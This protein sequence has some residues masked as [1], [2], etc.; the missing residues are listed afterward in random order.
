MSK[1]TKRACDTPYKTMIG[2][3]AL[4]EG[5]MMLGPEKKA[6]VVRKPDGT[7]EEQVE[8]RVLIKDKHPLLGLPLIRGVFNF[9]SSMANGVKAL[10]YSASFVPEDEET[11]EEPSKLEVWLDKHLGSEK[12]ASALVTLAVVLGMLFSV[13]LFILLPTALVGLLGKA[14][15]LAMWVRNLLEGV[16][17]IVIFAGYLMLCSHTKEIHRVFQYHGAEHKTI[18]CYEHGLPLTVENVRKQ[19]R[20]HPRCG[21]SFLF[22]VIVVSILLSS[23]VFTY[24]DVVN[25]FVRMGL[26]LLL[27][28]VIVS[29]TYEFNRLVGRYDNWFTRVMTAPG[30]WLQNWTTFEPDDSMI[31]V[32]IRA[33][34]LVL[35]SEEGKDQW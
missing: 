30:L 4:I 26:H 1:E 2:G 33:F 8:E 23:V 22:V 14:V 28:P 25:T 15:P 6:V 16:V 17:R 9:C 29:L 20:H 24:V 19:P 10:M 35:P 7:L 5:I 31:E 34:T 18:F 3:Q 11:P 27:L 32:G 21:T 12:A 13:V